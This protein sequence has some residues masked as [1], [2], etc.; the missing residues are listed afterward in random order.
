MKIFASSTSMEF[1]K[2]TL[3]YWTDEDFAELAKTETAGEMYDIAKRVLSRMPS[4]IVQVCGPVGSGGFGNIEEN[5][6]AFN[7]EIKKLQAQGLHVFDQM[8][9]EMPM[10]EL[11]KKTTL[12]E[13]VSGILNDFYLPLA[14]GAIIRTWY[15]MSN[16]QTSKGCKWEH[17]LAGK[18][19]IEIKYL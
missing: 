6:H 14:K 1:S 9:F 12:E 11:K 13:A 19:G 15:F 10:Q 16:W 7:E 8:P 17:E 18:L 2:E 3:K 5:L 4:P